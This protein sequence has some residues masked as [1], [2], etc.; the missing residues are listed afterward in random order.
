MFKHILFVYAEIHT[1][2]I[3]FGHPKLFFIRYV[4]VAENSVVL[5][6]VVMGLIIENIYSYFSLVSGRPGESRFREKW[7]KDIIESKVI[8]MNGI[9]F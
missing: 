4:L 9:H 8:T 6:T 2:M 7:L 3:D 1:K 5:R